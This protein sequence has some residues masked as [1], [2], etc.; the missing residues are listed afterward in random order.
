[1]ENSHI[2]INLYIATNW[3]LRCSQKASQR[4]SSTLKIRSETEKE[5][6]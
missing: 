3:L 4:T 2:G 5:R 1:M 6:K